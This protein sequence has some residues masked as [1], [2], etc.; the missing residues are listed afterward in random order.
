MHFIRFILSEKLKTR[1]IEFKEISYRIA[2]LRLQITSSKYLIIVT[3]TH[4]SP[5]L[6]DLTEAKE[7][8]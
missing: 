6:E 8:L 1:V 4:T 3:I 5:S 7:K 2:V